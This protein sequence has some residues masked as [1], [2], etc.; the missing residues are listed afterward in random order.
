MQYGT[1]PS[2]ENSSFDRM[3]IAERPGYEQGYNGYQTGGQQQ[4]Y[5]NGYPQ[6]QLQQSGGGSPA[7]AYQGN[8]YQDQGRPAPPPK[9]DLGPARAPPMRLGKAAPSAPSQQ[10]AQALDNYGA[11]VGRE[12][13]KKSWLGRRFSRKD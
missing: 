7:Q 8:G 13:K 9:A 2:S 10:Q 6:Q 12:E 5:G 4:S 11:P 1:D 3:P